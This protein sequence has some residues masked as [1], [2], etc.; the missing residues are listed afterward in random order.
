MRHFT[1]SIMLI[2][3]LAAAAM[4]VYA[5]DDRGAEVSA[6]YMN[7]GGSMHGW[8]VQV[9]KPFTPQWSLMGEINGAR[10]RDCEDCEPMYRDISAL[11]GV[12]QVAAQ[13]TR[14]AVVATAR[15][16]VRECSSAPSFGLGVNGD[17]SL[18]RPYR[19][20]CCHRS[21]LACRR[22]APTPSGRCCRRWVS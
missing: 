14:L 1:L 21:R 6:G 2:T 20:R 19:Y 17:T 22:C 3:G 13:F 15:G 9:S 5:Q 18:P 16:R 12:R 11:G 7:I 10:A 4:P 8:N